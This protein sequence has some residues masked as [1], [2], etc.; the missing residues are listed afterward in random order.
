MPAIE[1]PPT[2]VAPNLV[3]VSQSQKE[4]YHEF[5]RLYT[6]VMRDPLA[7]TTIQETHTLEKRVIHRTLPKTELRVSAY[8]LPAQVYWP[9]NDY[10]RRIGVIDPDFELELELKDSVAPYTDIQDPFAQL[11][12]SYFRSHLVA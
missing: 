5:G 9:E 12:M 11:V 10:S 7:V 1:Q 2:A 6:A 3:V 4:A 8:A